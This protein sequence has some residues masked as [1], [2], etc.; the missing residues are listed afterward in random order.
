MEEGNRNSNGN[1]PSKQF[2]E[3]L[4]QVSND[5]ILFFMPAKASQMCLKG[6]G[7]ADSARLLCAVVQES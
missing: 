5:M 7:H 3:K 6:T 2:G 4:E 1:R